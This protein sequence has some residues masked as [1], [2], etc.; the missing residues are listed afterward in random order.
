MNTNFDD[1]IM[2]SERRHRIFSYSKSHV[3]H[4]GSL[5]VVVSFSVSIKPYIL[6]Q[7]SNTKLS[8]CTVKSFNFADTNF[9]EFAKMDC[10]RGSNFRESEINFRGL[11][12][13]TTY[14]I[15]LCILLLIY[16]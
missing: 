7:E 6:G 12:S 13:L 5:D 11:Y 14:S 3:P 9:R 1:V 16:S 4:V 8:V 2:T 15:Y 10:F